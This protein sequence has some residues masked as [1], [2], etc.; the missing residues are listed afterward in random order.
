MEESNNNWEPVKPESTDSGE[1]A[2]KE[3]AEKTNAEVVIELVE[4]VSRELKK[5]HE[6]QYSFR[7]APKTAALALYAQLKLND[8]L[9]DS[10]LRAKEKKSIVDEVEAEQ[11]FYY[12]EMKKSE[13]ITDQALKHFVAKDNK[14]IAAKREQFAAEAEFSKYKNLFGILNNSHVF[15]RN[16]GNEK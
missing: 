15:F 9:S 7:E 8:F 10:D 1:L 6:E 14:V 4:K 5:A 3:P 12:K 2:Y 13:K 16:F 11:Y